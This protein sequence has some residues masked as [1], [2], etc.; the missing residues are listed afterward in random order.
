MRSLPLASTMTYSSPTLRGATPEP[1]RHRA[2]TTKIA[3]FVGVTLAVGIA[4]RVREALL[5]PLWFDEIYTLWMARL[6]PHAILAALLGDVHPP[7]HA[8]AVWAWRS[9]GGEGDLWIKTLSIVP[10][11]ATLGATYGLA[12]D[13]FGRRAALLGMALLAIHPR[14]VYFSQESRPY[15]LLW[16]FLTLTVWMAWRWH[17]RGHRAWDAVAYVA[18]ATLALYTHYFA[19]FVLAFV[20]AWGLAVSF[21]DPRRAFGW[22][23][24]NVA[25]AVLFV[26]QL[27]VLLEQ[28][29]HLEGDHWMRRPSVYELYEVMR[30]LAFHARYLVLPLTGL[31]VLPLLRPGQRRPALLLWIV[32]ALPVMLSWGLS[33]EGAHLFLTKY[34]LFT[35]PAWCTLLAAGVAGFRKRELRGALAA[36]MLLFEARA[37]AFH[38]PLHESVDMA[39]IASYM[40][41]QVHPGDV[42]LHAETHSLLYFRHYHPDGARHVILLTEGRLPYYEG[43]EFIPRSWRVSPADLAALR[44][45]GTRWWG[46]WAHVGGR[47][48]SPAAALFENGSDAFPKRFGI[49]QLWHGIPAPPPMP[50]AWRTS[51]DRPS[52]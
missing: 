15:A 44:A 47:D 49:I 6:S 10:G 37:M 26:P 50:K 18:S 21:R 40:R 19:G 14:H 22:I 20:G 12:R 34:M 30:Q 9:I 42:V 11:I 38:E 46:I 29:R 52:P 8:L 25:V 4:L 43:P 2:R 28:F 5:T 35:L 45:R 31:A 33:R 32:S 39:R 13:T 41:T 1:S 36:G 24:L 3:V 51:M 16:L 23:A 7:L 27:K 48:V 17:Q